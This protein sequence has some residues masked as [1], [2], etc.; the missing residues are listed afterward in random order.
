M[1]LAAKSILADADRLAKML[2]VDRILED[3]EGGE[4]AEEASPHA[5]ETTA[6]D[7]TADTTA[8]KCARCGKEFKKASGLATHAKRCTAGQTAAT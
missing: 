7:A 2:D 8:N 1:K 4:G 6:A 3:G 5:A